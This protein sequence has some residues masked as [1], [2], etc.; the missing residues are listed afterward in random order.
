MQRIVW[1]CDQYGQIAHLK[2][3]SKG[4]FF[5]FFAAFKCDVGK[6]CQLFAKWFI[7]KLTC[8]I[9]IVAGDIIYHISTALQRSVLLQIWQWQVNQHKHTHRKHSCVSSAKWLSKSAT[10]CYIIRVLSVFLNFSA[11]NLHFPY[12][13][14]PSSFTN[15]W[16]SRFL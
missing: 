15:F 4:I 12:V 5:Y 7:S 11:F 16:P 8:V 14:T 13:S 1:N 2:V 3:I 9:Y 6:E 10:R